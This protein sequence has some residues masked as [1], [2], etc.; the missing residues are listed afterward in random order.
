MLEQLF[1]QLG[2]VLPTP[3]SRM[4]LPDKI[5][6]VDAGKLRFIDYIAGWRDKCA[7]EKVNDKTLESLY[8]ECQAELLVLDAENARYTNKD[9]GMYSIAASPGDM[10][11]VNPEEPENFDDSDD[12]DDPEDSD[13]LDNPD[14]PDDPDDP[15]YLESSAK[16]MSPLFWQQKKTIFCSY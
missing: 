2:G 10:V 6:I 15:E 11:G 16:R 14:D 5:T 12:P 9:S 1:D 3:G 7:I 13:G 4:S 8:S